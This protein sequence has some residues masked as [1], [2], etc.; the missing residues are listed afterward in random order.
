MTVIGGGC[1]VVFLSSSLLT[2]RGSG[3]RGWFDG[4]SSSTRSQAS[5]TCT[6][7][8]PSRCRRLA[9]I[10]RGSRPCSAPTA[11]RRGGPGRRSTS[12]TGRCTAP[13]RWPV[14]HSS[15]WRTSTTT[16]RPA[17]LTVG[18][19]GRPVGPTEAGPGLLPN[20]CTPT[21]SMP[22]PARSRP[23]ARSLG[24]L[25]DEQQLRAPRDPADVRR[26]LVG[27][28]PPRCRGG[29]RRRAG[30]VA[31]VDHPRPAARAAASC[32]AAT[33]CAGRGVPAPVLLIGSMWG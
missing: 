2:P 12:C 17:G 4:P 24:V 27:P 15:R 33:G 21:P 3:G 6:T 18:A 9:A 30:P 22:I 23:W 28:P 29:D 5:S 13:G 16:G 1:C 32:S 25:G 26:E 7:S 8:R 11:R 19:G 20:R 31:Q 14:D 10:R